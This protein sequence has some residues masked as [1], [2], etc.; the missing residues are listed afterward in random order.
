MPTAQASAEVGVLQH[1]GGRLAAELQ[2]QPL[3]GR[4][5]LFH[6][7]LADHRRAGERDQVDLGRQRQFLTHEVIRCGD[8][9]DDTGWDVGLLGDQPAQPGRVERGVRRR[10]E[11][12]GVAGAQRLAELVE[13]DFEREV[14]RHDRADHADRLPPDLAGGQRAGQADHLVAQVGLPRVLVDQPGGVLQSVFQRGI[15]LGS[16]RDGPGRA[17]LEDELLAQLIDLGLDRVVQLQQAALAQLLVGRPVGLVEGAAGGVD[18]P[19]HVL[20][21]RVGDFAE[22]LLGRRVD[23]G[24]GAG[25]AVDE[26][27]VDHHL[28]LEPD[29]Y[30]VSHICQL[31]FD[32]ALVRAPGADACME[33]LVTLW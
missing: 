13:G 27:A 28:R 23:V 20:L 3:H 7:P 10:L 4:R 6:D 30:S 9:V 15:Q 26:L 32:E 2:E 11:H 14:P 21:R 1:D 17:D 5:A 12:D 18:G 33:R 31:S 25:L 8:H 19:V 16:E 29:L 22:R 24:E